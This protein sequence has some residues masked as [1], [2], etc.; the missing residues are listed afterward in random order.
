[1][2]TE[3][4]QDQPC[5]HVEPTKEHAWLKRFLGEWAFEHACPPTEPDGEPTTFQGR[6][7][8]RSI[9]D[10][11]IQGQGRGAMPGGGEA[12]MVITVG[13]DLSRGRFVGTWVG[14]MMTHMWI[15]EGWL[16][17]EDTLILEASG[18]RM[19]QPGKS[20]KY[21]DITEFSGPD[22]R[23]FRTL[24]LQEDGSWHQMM[25]AVFRRVQ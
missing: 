11:W 3:S 25:T 23:N 22:R 14:S 18:P 19:D 7:T 1:M 8:V 20:T 17:G 15:Y 21:R 12:N 2:S 4:T 24:V 9:G 13:F 10:L 5:M 6:E 16:E